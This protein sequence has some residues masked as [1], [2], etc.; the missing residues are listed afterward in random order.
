MKFR[1]EDVLTIPNILSAYRLARFPLGVLLIFLGR[2]G[3]YFWLVVFNQFT[4]IAD[5][6]IA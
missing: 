5:G 6:F 3:F 4:D 1:D 2:E